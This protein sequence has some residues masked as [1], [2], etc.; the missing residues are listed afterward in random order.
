MI[1]LKLVLVLVVF[2]RVS[3]AEKQKADIFDARYVSSVIEADL[4][5]VGAKREFPYD[6]DTVWPISHA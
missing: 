4:A 2:A 1:L 3:S 6:Y 5:A